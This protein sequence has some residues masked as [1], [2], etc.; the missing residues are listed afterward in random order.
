MLNDSQNLQVMAL[1]AL[2]ATFEVLE[3]VRPAREVDRWKD[4]KI[5][6]FS[7]VVAVAAN[8]ASNYSVKGFVN[9][10]APGWM[11]GGWHV[12][13]GLPSAVRIVIAIFLVD[14]IIYWIHRAQHRFD[15]LWRTHA[16]HHS[17]EQ[18]YWF[19][20]FRT[21]FLHS[22]LYNIPQAAVPMIVF[23]LSP[24]EA[25]IGYS[26]GLLIQFWEHTNI[27][28]NIGP[29]KWVFIT[30]AYH[31]VHHSTEHSGTNFGTTFSLWDRIFGTYRDPA[32]VPATAPLGLGEP[33]DKKKMARM[34]VGV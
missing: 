26:I 34:L 9:A 31:R 21:S 18:L 1:F 16:W 22:L 11:L 27:D 12:L 33:Y 4:L 8:R 32:T 19:S 23:N 2:V 14:F 7:F 17:V 6:V 28:V 3:R 29:L 5:D 13:Q 20:G 10:W 15:S 25:G 30:P 24:L